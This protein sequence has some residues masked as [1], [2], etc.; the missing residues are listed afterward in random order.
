[1][2]ASLLLNEPTKGAG[3][4]RRLVN[5]RKA[6]WFERLDEPDTETSVEARPEERPRIETRTEA[7][8]RIEARIEIAPPVD[9]IT[10]IDALIDRKG[11]DEDAV[12]ALLLSMLSK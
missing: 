11:D 9:F 7:L 12:I 8:T 2:L 1:M 3:K 4:G 10:E 6:L 5:A